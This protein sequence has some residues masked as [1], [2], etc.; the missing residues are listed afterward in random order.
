VPRKARGDDRGETGQAGLKPGMSK[1]SSKR[2]CNDNRDPQ[3]VTRRTRRK[4]GG[5]LGDADRPM[6]GLFGSAIVGGNID[7]KSWLESLGI[8]PSIAGTIR[9]RAACIPFR[10]AGAW[11]LYTMKFHYSTDGWLLK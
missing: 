9:R 2:L 7:A 1:T 3:T 5:S 11:N 4:D 10:C 6:L 8:L